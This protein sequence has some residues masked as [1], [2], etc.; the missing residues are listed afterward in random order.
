MAKVIFF[1][2]L[3]IAKRSYTG[4]DRKGFLSRKYSLTQYQGHTLKPINVKVSQLIRSE[5]LQ[6]IASKMTI[7]RTKKKIKPNNPSNY[8]SLPCNN[9]VFNLNNEPSISYSLRN[10]CD[11][12]ED[13]KSN[14][15]IN[16]F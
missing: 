7:T 10:I 11:K 2:K 14:F 3:K 5:N 1:K 13:H 9:I 12:N 4:S 16:K 6:K 8:S 15:F